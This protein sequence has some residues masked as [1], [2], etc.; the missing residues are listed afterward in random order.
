MEAGADDAGGDDVDA[1]VVGGEVAG[2]CAGELGE[3]PF[4]DLV[5]GVAW[6]AAGACRGADEDDGTPFSLSHGGEEGAAEVV[7]GVD[8]NIECGAPGFRGD[9]EDVAW[10]GAAG[11]MDEEVDGA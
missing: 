8:M 9:F 4:D 7:D 5:G 11:G 2:E 3:G 10:D 1:D 6:A